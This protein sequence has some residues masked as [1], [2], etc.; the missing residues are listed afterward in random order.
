M[1]NNVLTNLP[2]NSNSALIHAGQR[3][4]SF[5]KNTGHTLKNCNNNSLI[6]FNEYLFY[7]KDLIILDNTGE[8]N[9]YL[10]ED[11]S[12][13][14]SI[15]KI[16]KMEKFIYDFCLESGENKKKIKQFASRFCR[17]KLRSRLQV[18][19][20]KIIVYLFQLNFGLIINHAFNN[21]PFSEETPIRISCILN[22]I[23]INY[24]WNNN[25]T[26][27]DNYERDLEYSNT[28]SKIRISLVHL[29]HY[30]NNDEV[31]IEKNQDIDIECSICYNNYKLEDCVKFNCKHEFC[32]EC[33]NQ[34]IKSKHSNCPNCR[35][36]INEITCYKEEPH[37]SLQQLQ[38]NFKKN[39]RNLI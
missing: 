15:V 14:N 35:S 37:I 13:Y 39:S 24:L 4:C 33:T 22:G 19:V 34:L 10:P 12:V 23:L 26:S 8:L 18:S 38:E 25:Q 7:I 32:V 20:N 29:F 6:A 16:E 11:N 36:E 28:V 30:K 31:N 2:P 3:K 5:C 1:I 27:N 9:I 17:C 21:T